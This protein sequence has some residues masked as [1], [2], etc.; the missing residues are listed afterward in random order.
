MA[1]NIN[2]DS[3]TPRTLERFVSIFEELVS[4]LPEGMKEAQLQKMYCADLA[5]FMLEG[6]GFAGKLPFTRGDAYIEVGIP[7]EFLRM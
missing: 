7:K 2:V 1:A 5:F 6:D 4:Q 3:A